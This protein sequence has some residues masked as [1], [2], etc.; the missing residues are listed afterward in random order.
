MSGGESSS[1][2]NGATSSGGGAA[3]NGAGGEG[4]DLYEM[5]DINSMIDPPSC[6]ADEGDLVSEEATSPPSAAAE[7]GDK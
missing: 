7:K 2:G 3:T 4:G 5:D 6:W 1:S